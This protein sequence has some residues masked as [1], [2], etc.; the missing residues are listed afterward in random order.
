MEILSPLRIW[1]TILTILSVAL[2]PSLSA[3]LQ[4]SHIPETF[5]LSDIDT[6]FGLSTTQVE[7]AA[8]EGGR[9]PGI[10]DD[11]INRNKDG[12]IEGGVNQ[13]GV[14]FYNHLI[15]EL[16]ANGITPFVTILHF[17]YPLAIQ[18]KLHGFLNSS[19]V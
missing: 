19:I 11:R 6:G 14:D 18:E 3:K 15:D 2:N 12:T 13:E 5:P 1:K 7:G 17:D 8:T 10:W 16:L 4:D 9:G